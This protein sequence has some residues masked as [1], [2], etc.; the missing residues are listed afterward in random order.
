MKKVQEYNDQIA[1]CSYCSYCQAICPVFLEDK[2]ESVLPRNRIQVIQCSLIDKSMPLTS[3]ALEIIDRCLLCTNC[4]QGCSSQVPIDEI[5]VAARAA[6]NEQKGSL[7]GMKNAVIGKMLKQRGL[8]GLIGKAGSIAQKV[9]IAVKDMPPLAGKTFDKLCTGTIQAEGQ[10]RG[11]VAYFVGCGTNFMFPDTGMAVVNVLTRNGIEVVIPEG[12]VC[13]G[14]PSMAEGDIKSASEMVKTNVRIFSGLEVDAI[15][16]DCTSCGM[17]FKE[18]F[19]RMLPEDDPLQED[20]THMTSRVWEVTDYLNNIGLYT[21]PDKMECTFTYHVPCHRA[22]SPTVRHAP[23][24]LLQQI[25]GAQYVELD[26]PERCCG[27]AGSFYMD[28]R[29]ISEA[30]RSRRVKDIEDSKADLVVTQCPVCRFYIKAG[31]KNKNTEV[32]HPVIML[33]RAYGINNA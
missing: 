1:K 23:R 2:V 15:V 19:A 27:A 21:G 13:C 30:I 16:T 4:T 7:S 12:Q 32:I 5:V 18:K 33:A 22:W 29:E 11:R 17:M 28:H 3:R 25:P 6:L 24:Q 9:G 20:I 10:V 31:L 26:Y 8:T 14:I